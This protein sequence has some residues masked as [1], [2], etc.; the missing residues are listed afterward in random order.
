MIELFSLGEIYPSDFLQTGEKPAT[1]KVEMKMVMDDRGRVR[2]EKTAPLNK[3][4]GKYWYRS[5]INE[6]MKD[7][8]KDV[9]YST[10]RYQSMNSDDIWLDIA[11]ND[12]TLLSYVPQN[13]MKIGIDPAED[14]YKWEAVR[15]CDLHIQE[16]F[17]KEIFRHRLGNRRAKIITSIAMF[18]D[19]PDPEQFICDVR[20]IMEEDGLWVMQLSY[21]PLMIRQMAFDNICHEH[22]WY[23]SLLDL[24]AMLMAN[25]LK[26]VDCEL[27]DVNGGSMRLYIRKEGWEN[28]NP[29]RDV[30]YFRVESLS[31]LERD[32]EMG[33]PEVWRKWFEEIKK[34]KEHTVKFIR[35]VKAGGFNVWAYG[36]S[37]K[38]NTLL[39]FFGLDHTLIDGIADRNRDKHGLRT[40]GTNIPIYS[41]EDMRKENPSYLL[42]LPWHFIEEFRERENNYI[43]GGGKLIVPCPKFQIISA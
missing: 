23:Y 12:G 9:V 13:Y 2:L 27:N 43:R 7:A 24:R 37:T 22:I 14:S 18:Y 21:S 28:R 32:I 25:G 3:M 31:A 1:D 17:S 41:E 42:V 30:Q 4:Y 11:C 5:G 20:D 8:L 34:L 40:I 19:V 38:G 35:D 6:T 29:V 16:F 15:H 26:V 39:Q 10:L 33:N 36:A